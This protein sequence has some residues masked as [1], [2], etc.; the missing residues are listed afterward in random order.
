MS[1]AVNVGAIAAPEASL[2]TVTVFDPLPANRP[3]APLDGALNVTATPAAPVTGQPSLFA[4]ATCRLVANAASSAAVCGVPAVSVSS[5][6]GFDDG[7][8]APAEPPG[9]SVSPC[10]GSGAAASV[11]T[12][13]AEASATSSP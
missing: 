8:L 6:G 5:F 11:P 13:L 1:F 3:L 10:A 12:T 2:P 9:A 7:Q 4:S